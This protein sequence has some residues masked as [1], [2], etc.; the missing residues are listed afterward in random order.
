VYWK[1]YTNYD[2]RTTEDH[3]NNGINIR[4]VRLADIYLMYAEALNELGRT[5]ES[6]QYIDKVRRRVNLPDLENSTVF[7]GIGNDPAKMREQI[8]H[9]RSCELAGESWRWL[10]LER[11]GFFDSA[12]KIAWLTNRDSEFANFVIGKSNRFPI[13]YREVNLVKGL[14]QNPGYE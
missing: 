3:E 14:K 1:K 4:V 8:I 2:T 7:T 12:D 13:P 5:S 11:W 6:Y 10:D 9:E